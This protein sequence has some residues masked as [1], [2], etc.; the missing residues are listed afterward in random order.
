MQGKLFEPFAS[1]V[2]K[3]SAGHG[4][5]IAHNIVKTHGGII[6]LYIDKTHGGIIELYIDKTYGR[7]FE[8]TL[9][10]RDAQFDSVEDKHQAL[11]VSGFRQL[12]VDRM[13]RS[14]A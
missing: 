1:S 5:V 12:R 2:K 10:R 7:R 14:G 9:P 4:L 3:S 8:I 6:E 11:E 13:V